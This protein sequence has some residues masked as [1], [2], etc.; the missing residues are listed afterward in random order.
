MKVLIVQV[1]EGYYKEDFRIYNE[2]T[3]IVSEDTNVTLL[4]KGFKNYKGKFYDY[5]EGQ[6][7]T[8]VQFD[9]VTL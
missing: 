2:E 7:F 9:E 1:E 5:M 3:W 4:M 8:L 6:G